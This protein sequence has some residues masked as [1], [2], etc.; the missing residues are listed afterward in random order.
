[1]FYKI[2]LTL[3]LCVILTG[4]GLSTSNNHLRT[5]Q[6]RTLDPTTNVTYNGPSNTLQQH[7]SDHVQNGAFGYVHYT[8]KK[9]TN[10][11]LTGNHIPKIDYKALADIVTRLTLSLPT[12]YD[13][14]TLVTDQYVLIGYQSDN[15]DREEAAQQVKAAALSVVPNYYKIYVSDAHNATADLARY[16]A[17]S[18]SSSAVH[19]WLPA[20]IEQMKQSP[21]GTGNSKGVAD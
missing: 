5:G 12:V 10:N 13:A 8:R 19:R 4:C 6:N 7:N 11:A 1:M 14:G 21:Q 9:G 2:P 16:K 20:M 3:A 18:S 17:Y 15:P